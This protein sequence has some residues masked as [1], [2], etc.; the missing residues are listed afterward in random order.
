MGLCDWTNIVN[1]ILQSVILSLLL[2][3]IFFND[4]F[5]FS[6]KFEICYFAYDNSLYS[7]GMNLDN[8]FTNLIQDTW[9]V[10][11]CFVYNSIK[12]HPENV[13]FIILG[14][15][16]LHALQIGDIT[17]KSVSSVTLLGITIDS[18]LNFKKDINNIIKEAYYKLYTQRRL[19]MFLT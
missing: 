14:N 8:I 16:G 10:Y 3:N 13:Q 1:D 15:T 17:T 4:L 6:A 2:S 7:C 11:E 12:G 9:N 19:R 5:F 18:K